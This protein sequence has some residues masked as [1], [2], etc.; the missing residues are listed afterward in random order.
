MSEKKKFQKR[1]DTKCPDCD[2]TDSME[3][4]NH[5]EIID[6]VEYSES[7]LECNRCGYTEKMH[8]SLKKCRDPLLYNKKW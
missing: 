1:V 2:F 7:Y 8:K 4:V 5:I 6:G 3:M